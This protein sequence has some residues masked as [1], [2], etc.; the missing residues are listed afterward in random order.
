MMFVAACASFGT[1]VDIQ[2][3]R[4]E[5]IKQNYAAALPRFEQ[6][7]HAD[8]GYVTAFTEFPE[9]VWTYI[10]RSYYGL[11]DLA[12]ARAALE[13]SVEM[14]PDAI[15]GHVYLGLVQMRQGEV[16]PGLE[17]AERGL[18][19]LQAWFRTLDATNPKSNFWDPSNRIRNTTAQLIQQIGA[20]DVSWRQTASTLDWLGMQMEREIDLS[21]RD[22]MDSLRDNGDD[23]PR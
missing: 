18:E 21:K 3:G 6:A 15:L 4:R 8:P 17:N 9:N 14:H 20:S 16:R 13:R 19:L 11:G 23:T 10:G 1:S 2:A 12:R 5:L 22:I 7:A